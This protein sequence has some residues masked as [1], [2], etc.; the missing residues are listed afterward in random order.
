M[1][2]LL[3]RID[4]KLADKK[5]RVIGTGQDARALRNLTDLLESGDSPDRLK[6]YYAAL[7]AYRLTLLATQG[8]SASQG[9]APRPAQ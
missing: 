3:D 6:S 8:S 1:R 2:E 9:A 5:I 7:L 4:K